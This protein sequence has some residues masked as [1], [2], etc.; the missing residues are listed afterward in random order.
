MLI[1][2]KKL[3]IIKKKI[4]NI[5]NLNS[6]NKIYKKYLGKKGILNKFIKKIKNYPTHLKPIL[7]KEINKY[8]KKILKY[9]NLQIKIIKKNKK[10]KK[11]IIDLSLPGK[12][13]SLMGNKH[14]ITI[15]SNM[16]ETF[17]NNLGFKTIFGPEIENIY[18][19]FDALNIS[20]NHPSR[21]KKDTFWINNKYLL[22]TQTSCLQIRYMEKHNPPIK[23]IT[24][25][26]VFRKDFDSTHTPM[27]HQ[28][29]GFLID[30][31]ISFANLKYLIKKFIENFFN[32]EKKLKFYPAYFPFTEPSMEVSIKHIN[33]NWL[34]I[35]GC[36]LIHPEILKNADINPKKYSGLAFG[37]GIE[38]LTMLKFNIPDIRIL[39]ENNIKILKQF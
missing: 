17:F 11:Q 4:K 14:P 30:K 3:K 39:Y 38:R 34:E 28:L 24:L 32:K 8:K 27:F 15:I 19:N 29:E 5:K 23:A 25:G 37:I 2:F 12:N 26:K 33:N 13:Y 21:T 36:G 31:N 6:I 20:N 1:I 18:Y 16:L 7:G 22:R 10:K 9:I 35:L